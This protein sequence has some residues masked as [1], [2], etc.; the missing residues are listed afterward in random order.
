MAISL[1]LPVV[2]T[3]QPNL[4][5]MVIKMFPRILAWTFSSATLGLAPRNRSSSMSLNARCAGSMGTTQR[6]I[7]RLE[8]SSLASLILPSEE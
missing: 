1:L 8:A 2:K 5:E 4:L 7:P 3:I 6:S